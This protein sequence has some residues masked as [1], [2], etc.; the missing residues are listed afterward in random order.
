M[1][2]ISPIWRSHCD[3][4]MNA[5]AALVSS[6]G[7]FSLSTLEI[8]SNPGM[9]GFAL[10]ERKQPD[11]WRWATVSVEGPIVDEGWKTTQAEAKKSA[12][13]ALQHRR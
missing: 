2:F 7:S 3:I 10:T 12:I 5:E 9:A 13:N 4:H 1:A 8:A 11:L 6:S